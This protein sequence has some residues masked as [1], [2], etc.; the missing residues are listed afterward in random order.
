MGRAL[1]LLLPLVLI[2]LAAFWAGRAST[3]RQWKERTLTAERTSNEL[4]KAVSSAEETLS[5]LRSDPT[6]PYEAWPALEV[7]KRDLHN[8]LY[9]TKPEGIEK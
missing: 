6:M 3:A 8:A 4:R 1:V 9:P 5:D 7:A 2:V